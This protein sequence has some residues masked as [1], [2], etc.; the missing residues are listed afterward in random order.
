MKKVAIIVGSI[1]NDS[2]NAKLA[3]QMM[4]RYKH[5]VKF[6]LLSIKDIPIYNQD[7][8]LNPPESVSIFKQGI[9]R[10]DG[11]IFI[12]PEYNHT[13]PGGLKNAIDWASRVEK[14]LFEKPVMVAGVTPGIGGTIRAQ[15]HLKVAL[16][17]NHAYILPSNEVF[18]TFIDEKTNNKG[19]IIDQMT[20]EFLDQTIDNFIKWIDLVRRDIHIEL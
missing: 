8:E 16:D 17:A 5:K 6:N 15:E 18:V 4:E 14:V 10:S 11:V 13:I 2:V 19:E 1:R 20:L 9:K 12:T 3:I 7:D